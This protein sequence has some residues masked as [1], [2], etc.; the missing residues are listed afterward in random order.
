MSRAFHPVNAADCV[1]IV[2]TQATHPM[3]SMENCTS[4]VGTRREAAEEA[5]PPPL[6][7]ALQRAS[8]PPSRTGTFGGGTAPRAGAS[9]TRSGRWRRRAFALHGEELDGPPLTAWPATASAMNMS[10]PR[11]EDGVEPSAPNAEEVEGEL[12]RAAGRRGGDDGPP[13]ERVR[14]GHDVD[15][16]DLERGA[17]GRRQRRRG[18]EHEEH[19]APCQHSR[20]KPPVAEHVVLVPSG[21]PLGRHAFPPTHTGTPGSSRNPGVPRRHPRLPP[22]ASSSLPRGLSL[23]LPRPCTLKHAR[24]GRSPCGRV[25]ISPERERG[26]ISSC[27]L[28]ASPLKGPPPHRFGVPRGPGGVGAAGRVLPARPPPPPPRACLLLPGG[29][30]PPPRRART[31]RAPPAGP[32]PP[33]PPPRARRIRAPLSQC[34]PP[35]QEFFPRPGGGGGRRAPGPPRPIKGA[36]SQYNLWSLRQV[37]YNWVLGNIFKRR[38]GFGNSTLNSARGD[39]TVHTHCVTSARRWH[40]VGGDEDEDEDG[41]GAGGSVAG[42]GGGG[43]GGAGGGGRGRGGAVGGGQCA[44]C[45]GSTR[46]SS[47]QPNAAAT[48]AT[49]LPA[50]SP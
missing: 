46:T 10:A 27:N 40:A 15:L 33:A 49:F 30:R 45:T 12:H 34:H 32:R 47:R 19:S 4:T 11:P 7:V 1:P 5:S 22:A 28:C 13:P 24:A 39:I 50:G 37:G 23:P 36:F 29:T 21:L 8:C 48:M 17:A 41:D 16:D 25:P 9:C 44:T 31:P 6:V 14:A 42:G 3:F 2:V 35:R 43:G 38:R 20:D 26:N 18:D